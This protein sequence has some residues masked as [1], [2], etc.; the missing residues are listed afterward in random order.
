MKAYWVQVFDKNLTSWIDV[1][2]EVYEQ[3]MGVGIKNPWHF[4]ILADLAAEQMNQSD[5]ALCALEHCDDLDAMFRVVE[6]NEENLEE[7][8]L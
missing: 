2:R 1:P 4:K 3:L 7:M 6:R 8:K 5:W